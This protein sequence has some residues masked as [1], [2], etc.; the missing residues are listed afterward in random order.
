[1]F[2]SPDGEIPL[3]KFDLHFCIGNISTD[4]KEVTA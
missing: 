4:T 2:T 3:Q 1:M